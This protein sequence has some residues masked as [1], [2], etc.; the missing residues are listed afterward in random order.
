[1]I[2]KQSD[3]DAQSSACQWISRGTRINQIAGETET[4]KS[5]GNR[6]VLIPGNGTNPSILKTDTPPKPTSSLKMK[7]L[8]LR[9][10]CDLIIYWKYLTNYCSL[11][12]NTTCFT[13]LVLPLKFNLNVPNVQ[14]LYSA[15]NPLGVKLYQHIQ[16]RLYAILNVLRRKPW[17]IIQEGAT[18]YNKLLV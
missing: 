1:M 16:R 4:A 12:P 11:R 3:K 5:L 9:R 10:S 8:L 14:Y 2:L 15:I 17:T 18:Q 7:P 6:D 13:V